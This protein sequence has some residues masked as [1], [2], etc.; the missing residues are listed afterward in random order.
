MKRIFHPIAVIAVQ[1]W[2]ALAAC[3]GCDEPPPDRP[4]GSPPGVSWKGDDSGYHSIAPMA[5]GKG[6]DHA[7]QQA[8]P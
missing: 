4:K 3:I 1:L 5:Q 7:R 2:T 6:R 8:N